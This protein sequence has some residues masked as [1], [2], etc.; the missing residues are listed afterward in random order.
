M[1]PRK[2]GPFTDMCVLVG[3]LWERPKQVLC[4]F[5][6]PG[7][8]SP[9]RKG[10]SEPVSKED[11]YEFRSGEL[12]QYGISVNSVRRYCVSF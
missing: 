6:L 11:R 8:A 12:L 10:K 2:I 9:Y 3:N 7:E 1:E 4:V 5:Y